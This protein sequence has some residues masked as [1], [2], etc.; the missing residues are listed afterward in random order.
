MAV[1]VKNPTETS[2]RPGL[3]RLAV[4]SL[5]GTLYVLISLAVVF[6][7]IPTLWGMVISPHLARLSAVD[8]TLM[9]LVMAGAAGG[10]GYYGVRLLGPN[11]LHGL[12]A[13]IFA[14][15]VLVFVVAVVAEWL[16]GIFERI[17]YSTRMFGDSGPAVGMGVTALIGLCLL[18]L[19]VRFFFRPGFERQVG[20]VEDQ[21]WFSLASYK[22]TQG[23]RVRRG[24]I[25]GILVLG[26]CGIYTLLAH[27]S[28]ESGPTDWGLS[29]P[30]TGKVT[31]TD[32]GDTRELKSTIL[33]SADKIRIID[34]GKG[35]VAD[36][37]RGTIV[38]RQEFDAEVA[39]RKAAGQQAP[40]AGPLVDRFALRDL[41]SSFTAEYE[42]ITDPGKSDYKK[43]QL[44]PKQEY[45]KERA[46]LEQE[47]QAAPNGE[48]PRPA[49]GIPDYSHISLL[50]HVR[51]T[52]P[53]LLTVFSLWFAYR[54]VNFPPFADFLI[55]TEAELN[56]VSWITRRR[57]IQDSVVVLVTMLLMTVFLFVIDIVWWAAL[58][59]RYVG[60]IRAS[61][62]TVSTAEIDNQ[63]QELENAEIA[64]EDAQKKKE[65]HDQIALLKRQRET[66]KHE[67][68]E[69]RLDW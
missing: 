11:P 7:A 48:P 66:M 37:R 8:V 42:R 65:I 49:S 39:R 45:R 26:A 60:V 6:Y 9:L 2:S 50:P 41:N 3:N 29:V 22:R 33:D 23:Q 52:L 21:G 14:G 18:I 1:A 64:Q 38:S 46:R 59:N 34:P 44:V 13:G 35:G 47:N 15:L 43:G 10:L 53:I 4:G 12:K 17:I 57:L 51:F 5:L 27:H 56:K 58:S 30:F 67:K 24:T 54:L 25:M 62:E 61:D 40:V 68:P 20:R 63:I 16:G 28:L 32:P 19:G 55:A 69:D 31:V 36:W